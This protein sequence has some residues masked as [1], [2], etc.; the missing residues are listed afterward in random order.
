MRRRLLVPGPSF[1]WAG[2]SRW[3]QAL[4]WLLRSAII[5]VA[6]IAAY[7]MLVYLLLPLALNL[8]AGS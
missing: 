6:A 7:L 8:Q 1:G 4:A 3:R 2:D 5:V